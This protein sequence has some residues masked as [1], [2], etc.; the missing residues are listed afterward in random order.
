MPEGME[1]PRIIVRLQYLRLLIF[2]SAFIHK[3]LDDCSYA[4]VSTES[5]SLPR[6][7][8]IWIVIIELVLGSNVHVSPTMS[9][10]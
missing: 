7:I 9:P 10:R 6:R 3:V 1:S 4:F 8:F 2:G 5:V